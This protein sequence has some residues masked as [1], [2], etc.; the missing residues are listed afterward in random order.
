MTFLVIVIAHLVCL[1]VVIELIALA[2][3]D[4]SRSRF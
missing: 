1:A 2:P 3:P 4:R